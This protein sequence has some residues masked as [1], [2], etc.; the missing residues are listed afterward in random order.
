MRWWR[1]VV[2]AID[3][4]TDALTPG[5]APE[6]DWPRSDGGDCLSC[7]ARGERG[8]P[9]HAPGEGCVDYERTKA[10]AAEYRAHIERYGAYFPG[11]VLGRRPGS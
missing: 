7:G 1:K 4:V 11:D 5:R 2:E 3:D 10:L 9:A 8:H 6:D